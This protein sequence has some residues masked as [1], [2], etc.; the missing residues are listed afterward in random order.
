MDILA[1]LNM[2]NVLSAFP[3]AN[4]KGTRIDTTVSSTEIELFI[5]T[6][7]KL[8][9]LHC[10]IP[11]CTPARLLCSLDRSPIIRIRDNRAIFLV[12]P[13]SSYPSSRRSGGRLAFLCPLEIC[14]TGGAGRGR[15][16]EP[17]VAE[18]MGTPP[19]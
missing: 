16:G 14:K 8:C 3:L 12:L 2:L 10:S 5:Y 19:T 13:A 15:E 9:H 1:S 7:R 11:L 4:T 18:P 17:E 6:C